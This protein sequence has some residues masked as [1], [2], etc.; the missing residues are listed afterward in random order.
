VQNAAPLEG[1]L[2][3]GNAAAAF[4][5]YT[6]DVVFGTGGSS[7]AGSLLAGTSLPTGI[8]N[9]AYFDAD[10]VNG[11][12]LGGLLV[13][14]KGSVAVNAP[15]S[16]APGAQIKLFAPI[17][18]VAANITAPSGSVTIGNVVPAGQIGAS[19]TILTTAGGKAQLTLEAGGTIDTRGLWSNGLIDQA[20]LS[21]L[22]FVNGGSVIFDS[23]Q[24]V[25]LAAGSTID[26]SSGAAILANGKTVGGKGGSV[27]LTANDPLG[28]GNSNAPFVLGGAIR[29]YG[30][31][32]GG[33]LTVGASSVLIASAGTTTAAGQVLLT[34]DFFTTGFSNYNI[35]GYKG[36]TV[37]NDTQINVVEPVY[38][39][40]DVSYAAP[41]GSDPS[42]ALQI[43][44]P[45]SLYLENPTKA[46]LTQRAGASLSLRSST[47]LA[48]GDLSIGQG[49]A[50]SVDP[51][52][53]VTLD[54]FGQITVDGTI[55]A[56]GGAIKIISEANYTTQAGLNFDS[57]GN[58][59][60]RSVWIGDHATL[61]V[62]GLAYTALD[63]SGRAYGVAGDGG[64]IQIGGVA[65]IDSVSGAL[66][67]TSS[68]V[69]IRPGAVLDASGASTIIDPRAGTG[70]NFVSAG[71]NSVAPLTI[72]GNGGSIALDSSSGIYLDG[73][74]RAASGSA[75]AAGGSLSMT[76]ET[77]VYL[78]RIAGFVPTVAQVPSIITI[79][80]DA[81]TSGLP[82]NLAPGA[83]GSALK[84]G[85]AKI[86]ADAVTAGGF[87]NVSLFARD[88]FLFAGDVTLKA[89]QS[90]KLYQGAFADT[91]P[92]ANVTIA[93]PYVL[94]GGHTGIKSDFAVYPALS[95]TPSSASTQATFNVAADLIDFQNDVRFLTSGR[96]NGT[97]YNL[98]GFQNANFASQGDV[99]FLA[100]VAT[101]AGI[102]EATRILTPGSFAFTAA[103]LYPVTGASAVVSAGD[104]IAVGRINNI[105]PGVPMSVF[106]RL[107]LAASSIH[108]GGII[109]APLG[110][111][112]IGAAG[113]TPFGGVSA[114]TNVVELLPGSITSVSADGL[115]IPYGGTTDG[116][117]YSYGGTAAQALAFPIDIF[118]RI[119]QGVSLAG[120]SIDVQGGATLNLSGGG[121]LTG[122]GFISG[123]GG[124]VDVLTTPLVNANPNNTYSAAGNKVYAIV[125]SYRSGYAPIAV[126]N[127]A[128]DPAIGQQITIPAGV[129]GLPAGTYTLFPSNYALLPGAY[130]VEVG[131]TIS[132]S[133]ASFAGTLGNGSYGIAGYKSIANTSINAALPTRLIITAADAVRHYS[134][135]NE[136]GY[137]DFLVASAAL[138]GQPRRVLPADAKTLMI[139]FVQPSAGGTTPSLNFDGTA[140]FQP[141]AGGFGGTA[142]IGGG[143]ALE[144][145][146]PGV[147]PTSGFGGISLDMADLNAIGA[148]RLVV[149]GFE[150]LRTGTTEIHVQTTT[151]NLIIRNG[152][153][154]SAG[155][156][157]L[158]SSGGITVE[159]GATISTIGQGAA[160]FDSSNGYIYAIEGTALLLSNGELNVIAAGGSG[161][162]SIGAGASL[163]S[164]GT[165]A[166][167]TN[168]AVTIDAGARYGTKILTLAAA[169]INVGNGASLGVTVP[170]G[171]GF[172]QALF[173]RLVAGAGAGAPAGVPA[174]QQLVLGAS[175]SVNFYGTT[176]LDASGTDIQLILSTP[177]I[178]G[179]GAAADTASLKAGTLVWSGVSGATLPAIAP[180]GAGTGFG[181]LDISA[182]TIILGYS[183]SAIPNGQ[184]SLDRATYGFSNVNLTATQRIVSNNKGSLSVYQAPSTAPGTILGKNGTDGDLNITA[185][186]LT[187][188]ASSIMA[189]TAGGALKVTAPAG[190]AATPSTG[191]LGAEIDLTGA[192]V[193]I[194]STI[195]LPSGKLVVTANTG[196]VAIH[197]GAMLD[198]S[199]RATTIQDQAVYGFGGDVLLSST[200]GNIIQELGSTLD[201]S[202]VGNAAGSIT[203]AAIDAA[204]GQVALNGTLRGSSTLSS[205]VTGGFITISAQTLQS[206]TAANLSSDFAALNTSLN[207]AGFSGSR[208]FDLRQGNLTIGN[209]VRAHS[210]TVS[211]DGGSLTVNG[212]IDASGKTPGTIR[213]G[214]RDDLELT[215][216]GKLDAHGT[217]LQVDSYGKPIEAKN[218]ATI[219]LTTTQGVLRFGTGASMDV[220][221]TSPQGAM[222]ASFGQIDLNAPRG[223]IG[224]VATSGDET[225]GD[226]KID[227][228]GALRIVGARSIAVNGF[229]TYDLPGGSV[230][231]QATLDGYDT[232]STAFI[233]AALG[234]AGLSARLAGLTAYGNAFHLR[235]GVEITS[236]GDLSTSGDIDLSRYRYGQAAD[237]N[238]ASA[239]YGAGEP[240]SLAIRAGGNLDIKGSL[241]DGFKSKPSIAGVPPTY[242]TVVTA[243]GTVLDTTLVFTDDVTLTTDWVVPNDDYYRNVVYYLSD[244]AG[245][246]YNPGDRVPAGTTIVADGYDA[247]ERGVTLPGYSTA[248]MT[249]P[250]TPA[251]PAAAA[252]SAVAP[253]LAPG[254]LSTSIRLVA[255]A[256]LAAADRRALQ[257][258]AA[259]NGSGNL[260][261]NDPTFDTSLRGN[262]SVVRTGTGSLELLAGG[263]FSEVTPF[264]VYTAGTDSAPILAPDGSNPYDLLTTASGGVR[265]AYYP[266]HGGDLLLSAQGNVSGYISPRN[267]NTDQW[268]DGAAVGQW[269]W[270]QGGAIA[271]Q[272]AAWWINF[273]SYVSYTN[274]P[275]MTGF[276]GIGTLGG[277]NLTVIA[278]GN[279]G[280][281]N[282]ATN[283]GLNL[284]VASTGRVLAD[285]TVVQTGGGD[286]TLRI[287]GAFNPKVSN[288][289][290]DADLN[291]TF[292]DL[293]GDISIKAASIGAIIPGFANGTR[294]DP[295]DPR[296][297][298]YRE[299]E[300]A[301]ILGGPIVVPG[302][303]TVTIATRGDLV[304]GGAGDA[305]ML[306]PVDPNGM[307][308]LLGGSIVSKGGNGSFTLWT[309][310]TAINLYSAGGNLSPGATSPAYGANQNNGFNLYPATL[311]AAA[312]SGNL[313]FSAPVGPIE[314]AP[315]PIGQL[316]LLAAGSI[317]GAGAIIAMSGAD[318]SSLATPLNPVFG[319]TSGAGLTNAS[320]NSA[321]LLISRNSPIAFGPDTPTTNLHEGDAQPGLVYAGNDIVNLE[322]GYI[323]AFTPNGAQTKL[324]WYYGAKPFR[325][326]AGRDIIGGAVPK[327]GDMPRSVNFLLNNNPTD[328][329]VV[330]AGRDI[331]NDSITIGGPGLLDVQAGR[332]LYQGYLGT[333]ESVGPLVNID[334]S[335]RSS[336]AGI[337]VMAGVG[338]KGPD[339]ADF[340]RLYFDPANQLPVGT[341]L[342]G[343]GK[344]AKTYG[345]ELTDWLT[346]RFSLAQNFVSGGKSFVFTGS[347]ADALAFF[348]ALPVEQQGV[349]VRQ[350]Y[351]AELT[352]G[353]R[354]YNDPSSSRYRSYLRGRDAIAALFPD[355]DANGQP[356]TYTGNITMFSGK[357][358]YDG[359]GNLDVVFDPTH[360]SK[361]FDAGIR[362]NSGGSIQILTP[363]GQTIVGVEGLTP[364]ANAGLLTQG[365]GDIDIY[366]LGSLLLGQ[367]RVMTTFGG[368]ILA[369][370]ARGDINAGR[371]SKTTTVFTPPKRVYDNYG[372]VTL[373]PTVPSSGAGIAT[374][375]PIPEVKAGNIDLIAPLGTIDAG[376]AGIRVSGNVNLAALQVLNAANIQVQGTSTG[377]PT[378]Q[379]P[380]IAAALSTSNATA[381]TQ[382]T[383]TPNQ[384]SGNER[385]SV[386]IVEV[387]GYGGGTDGEQ[388][389]K[390][391]EDE[392]KQTYN[393]SAPVRVVGYGPVRSSDTGDL[394]EEEKRALRN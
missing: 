74:L 370:S 36:V 254:S 218:R 255:G 275:V 144:V 239:G 71:G 187:G 196:D 108:Q 246:A 279:A 22:A 70:S 286:L 372:N 350:V 303:G 312:A 377:I 84:F 231:T 192:S 393:P 109:R 48:G 347:K 277:G 215:A 42:S 103:Q 199:G 376:E 226:I 124:S 1:T 94:F 101:L 223:T 359:V 374:L 363:G 26:V 151:G 12:N 368:N 306:N 316:S 220:S 161:A 371:G 292:T 131:A 361:Q 289:G 69:V 234:N 33:T 305:A 390:K 29:A 300:L 225:S 337:S 267:G 336:G 20:D 73:T 114:T 119:L 216:S 96:E 343:S 141:A 39:F 346:Q 153:T 76:L 13:T 314:L 190:A 213:L 98:A 219:E 233:N 140:L 280:T 284:A 259:L 35:N 388:P 67:S 77:P 62:S 188:T 123:R 373:A 285:G 290:G 127:G 133:Q 307:P 158:T 356:L 329:S 367:S 129:P 117:S 162:I 143:S 185:P 242:A 394:T 378:V 222:L 324:T 195:I 243:A 171:I 229:W 83:N 58:P 238:T 95:L 256:D 37:A 311:I 193:E 191:N 150:F 386:I 264:G 172:D 296:P 167:A 57:T 344:V 2:A 182:G 93:A 330:R 18:D 118:G 272:S 227:A 72:A 110:V 204:A 248:K 85:Q 334:P 179:Y 281:L 38:R 228:S 86:G 134:Q 30:V 269:L 358:S 102:A 369:W 180:N 268:F 384:G 295:S 383:A 366:S 197:A 61:D 106:G 147:G 125:P 309:P 274:G 28:S 82:A 174:L 168:G 105:D 325:I 166:F 112:A 88:A 8:V 217:A 355:K 100:P 206:G 266:E 7:V 156:V 149:G 34:P 319:L 92:I 253:M 21:G 138:F 342:D 203:A 352:A 135:Y 252:T 354:E 32:G 214:A 302:D 165:L 283:S 236:S 5:V 91:V 379:A 339:Y 160:P 159:T 297:L 301:Q 175:K 40:A 201:V 139:Q 321:Y 19:T 357:A 75:G 270:H 136:Q 164:E 177:A 257:T 122:R 345:D 6:T 130:R 282:G 25:T 210:V 387:L 247:F 348:L 351:Y 104:S 41:T 276:Q 120:K 54:A 115:I 360:V 271:G 244:T 381:A 291:G 65:G 265:Q 142:M 261:L 186:L 126:E 184:V 111:L 380:S 146:A 16:F 24:G 145:Y 232:A 385:P 66:L 237:R 200:H 176:G 322:I 245:N 55:T 308:Y 17:V 320:P 315:S 181:T 46:Q 293:R 263:N 327:T 349:F 250:G 391:R 169:N 155:E 183:N 113:N 278:G 178:Y 51:G 335:N 258:A 331:I 313:D 251:S 14:T 43:W 173:D 60:G 27:T 375:N 10:A 318:M 53:N 97:G 170:S 235:P 323:N 326:I 224:N 207:A 362:T 47:G 157:A 304:L 189:Y 107:A 81:Q 3:L 87:D 205:G 90:I 364:G 128:G 310:T 341:P 273:G 116:L 23:S 299:A 221:V 79:T 63:F 212:T 64:S 389:A 202:A 317:Y 9:T 333:L 332:N 208:A 288:F 89:N 230:I 56:H 59:L 340:A 328:I 198:L 152:V 260:K 262:F 80:Q 382:Q 78:N 49:A 68:F 121:N 287:G 240:M 249:D 99:R 4:N 209:E 148:S 294:I 211:V 44:L 154:L 137:S 31:N 50:I 241:S 365:S 353:G 52:Q 11:F 392:Q 194:A 338:A 163:Y 298:D 45:S 132:P 15:L